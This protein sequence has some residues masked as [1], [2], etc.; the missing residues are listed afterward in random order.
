[1]VAVQG[2]TRHTDYSAVADVV[3]VPS[4][5]TAKEGIAAAFAVIED[6]RQAAA[7]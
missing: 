3:V 4:A 5:Q 1:M 2:V 7:G 6:H